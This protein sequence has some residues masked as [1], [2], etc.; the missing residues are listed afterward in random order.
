[1]GDLGW[2]LWHVSIVGQEPLLQLRVLVRV[3]QVPAPFKPRLDQ[4]EVPGQLQRGLGLPGCKHVHCRVKRIS[5]AGASRALNS[6]APTMAH[7]L[8]KYVSPFFK[9]FAL[10]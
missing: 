9:M 8:V 3:H 1:M 4:F 10:M 7:I 5:G 6:P 2:L